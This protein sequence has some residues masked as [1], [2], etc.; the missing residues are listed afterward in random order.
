[1][2]A[3]GSES[4]KYIPSFHYFTMLTNE[5]SL[6]EKLEEMQK[7]INQMACSLKEISQGVD[8]ANMK[9]DHLVETYSGDRSAYAHSQPQ[10]LFGDNH[11]E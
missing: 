8:Q 3:S 11:Q 2:P 1:M 7:A 5:K 9:L 10:D 4:F 6:D